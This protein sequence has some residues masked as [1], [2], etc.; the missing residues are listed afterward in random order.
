MWATAPSH[1]IASPFKLNCL[2]PNALFHIP[3]TDI[4]SI[5]GAQNI[6]DHK[7]INPYDTSGNY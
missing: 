3:C 2:H 4:A 5:S 1:T 6:S 7:F